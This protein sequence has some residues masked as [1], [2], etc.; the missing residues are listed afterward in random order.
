[1]LRAIAAILVVI[2][3]SP[4][5]IKNTG[6]NYWVGGNAQFRA[7]QY[8]A[9]LNHLDFGV[10][11]FFCISGFIMCLLVVKS[12][13]TSASGLRFLLDRATRIFPPYWF[14]TA[15][16]VVAYLFSHGV[17]NVGYLSG[18]LQTDGLKLLT[19]I[20]M[21][22]QL[23]PP[24]LAV[25]WTLI[26]E[27]LFY[28]LCSLIISFGLNRQLPKILLLVSSLAIL[29]ALFNIKLLYGYLFSP[30][31][32]E[33]FI[34]ALVY[35]Y[36]DKTYSHPELILLIAIVSFV[37]SSYILD[38][39][40]L[41]NVSFITRQFCGAITGALLI[42]GLI[43]T[44]NKYLVSKMLIGKLLMRIGDASYSLY[45]MHWFVLSAMGKV[46]SV[47]V[48]APIAIVVTWHLISI[49]TAILLAVIFTEKIELP[50]YKMLKNKITNYLKA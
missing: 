12:P 30:Y 27:T 41:Q 11:I 7:S 43:G 42:I 18:N 22:P 21:I 15:L 28:L 32:L 13:K 14:F 35:K 19:S 40:H 2:W 44:D 45:L 47:F 8:P 29:L 16:V 4:L 24:I 1:M 9:L 5:A 20:F 37:T 48:K 31:Y 6:H 38:S 17:F 49:F 46:I 10:D 50:F 3:H 23:D 25:G 34:G 33:F 26:H 39:Q 36:I